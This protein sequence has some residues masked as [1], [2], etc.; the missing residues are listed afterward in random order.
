M[1]LQSIDAQLLTKNLRNLGVAHTPQS[2]Q[3]VFFGSATQITNSL[4]S[5]GAA[6]N[7]AIYS[8]ESNDD[9]VLAKGLTLAIAAL[10]ELKADF[11]VHRITLPEL[12]L[13]ALGETARLTGSIAWHDS[14]YR[15]HW[16]ATIPFGVETKKW[17]SHHHSL[18]DLLNRLPHLATS[19]ARDFDPPAEL[20]PTDFPVLN[21]E[22][23]VCKELL[24]ACWDFERQMF[25]NLAGAPVNDDE[26]QATIVRLIEVSHQRS[27]PFSRWLAQYS[28]VRSLLPGAPSLEIAMN[29][30]NS[31]LES[32]PQNG[33]GVALALR[34]LAQAGQPVLA[35]EKLH[36]C[37]QAAGR[38][39]HA[40]HNLADLYA[41]AHRLPEACEVVQRAIEA[42][43]E[44][45]EF[46]LQYAQLLVSSH[47]MEVE[48]QHLPLTE[49]TA[50]WGDADDAL[51]EAVA[52][53]QLELAIRPQNYAAKCESLLLQLELDP[54]AFWDGFT[55]LANEPAAIEELR[56]LIAEL[57]TMERDFLKGREILQA[58]CARYPTSIELRCAY[59]ECLLYLSEHDAAWIELE[60]LTS[61]PETRKEELRYLIEPLLLV[62]Q[63]PEFEF[64]LGEITSDIQR[65]S[66]RESDLVFLEDNLEL[67]PHQLNLYLLLSAGYQ[68]HGDL[69]SA[70]EILLEAN[71]FIKDE[72]DLLH[73][74][75]LTSW[76]MNQTEVAFRFLEKGL[77]L[78]PLNVPLLV[79]QA[80]Y[81]L[82]QDEEELAKKYMV[83]AESLD[84]QHPSMNQLK[85]FIA[86]RSNE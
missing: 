82:L 22:A 31:I 26:F 42:S 6:T 74:L 20:N 83:R 77:S 60:S 28:L 86:R 30:I 51:R 14:E 3:D 75:S 16:Q 63:D 41:R 52:A 68:I 15:L 23:S 36:E 8:L 38:N 9:D 84:E 78:D 57:Q 54:V 81:H 35:I 5:A 76:R 4:E 59:V 65:G 12:Q 67:A 43:D 18:P 80:L 79:Q 46:A 21:D 10:L 24:I 39:I 48:I 64:R 85:A 40:V 47:D 33:R 11:A 71:E 58:A 69:D 62:A 66:I 17:E 44:P 53:F 34:H 29:Q 19:I 45:H 2:S 50:T 13:P 1:K 27:C 73:H 55:E 25:L 7:L 70:M 49:R 32:L 56:H 37:I 61:M 72:P